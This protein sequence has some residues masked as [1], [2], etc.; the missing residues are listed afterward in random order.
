MDILNNRGGSPRLYRNTLVFL[1]PDRG[2]MEALEQTTRRYLAWKPILGE[3][4]QLNLDAHGRRQARENRE[5]LDGAVDLQVEEAYQWLLYPF[6][7]K[8]EER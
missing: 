7:E 6:E 1:A 3:E 5:K 4:E 8:Q 2:R